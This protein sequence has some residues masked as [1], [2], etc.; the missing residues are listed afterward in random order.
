[1]TH[2]SLESL[3][4]YDGIPRRR[5]PSLGEQVTP[6]MGA[7]LYD[8]VNDVLRIATCVTLVTY[9]NMRNSSHGC[10]PRQPA[11]W[12]LRDRCLPDRLHVLHLS[13]RVL[14][15]EVKDA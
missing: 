8:R 2:D 1:M 11:A 5:N 14:S 10:L 12:L 7:Y 4:P 15:I 13:G 6:W 9:R 3:I